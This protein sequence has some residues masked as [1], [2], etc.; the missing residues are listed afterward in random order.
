MIPSFLRPERL[1]FASVEIVP[2]THDEAFRRW[3]ASPQT[4]ATLDAMLADNARVDAE[5]LEADIADSAR[6]Q[7]EDDSHPGEACSPRCGYCG[8]CS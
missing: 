2:E 5:Q 4:T 7:L 1:P 3:L 6:E 8:G